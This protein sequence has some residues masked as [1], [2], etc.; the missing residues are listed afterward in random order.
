MV[1]TWDVLI[2]LWQ[3]INGIVNGETLTR[4]LVILVD[5]RLT[6]QL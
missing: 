3:R 1:G 5:N 2:L 4:I 6:C